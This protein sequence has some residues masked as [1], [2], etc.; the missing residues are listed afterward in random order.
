MKELYFLN[1]NF[2]IFSGRLCEKKELSLMV[3]YFLFLG[4]Y[5]F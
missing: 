3:K 1:F 5:F 2:L 4:Y